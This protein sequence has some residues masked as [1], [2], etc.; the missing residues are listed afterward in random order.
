MDCQHLAQA[1]ALGMGSILV[2]QMS[3]HAEQH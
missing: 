3:M 1:S 2:D